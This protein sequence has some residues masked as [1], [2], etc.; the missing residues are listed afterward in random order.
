MPHKR[1]PVVCERISGLARVVRGYALTALEDVALW[2]E[3]DISHSS[4]ERIVFPDATGLLSFMLRELTWV[5][6]GLHVFPER[7]RANVEVAGGI[8][9]SQAVLLA[10]VDAG[11]TRDDAYGLVQ[12]AAA[13]AWDRGGSFRAALERTPAIAERLDAAALDALFDPARALANLGHVFEKLEKLPVE[14]E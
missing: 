4:A 6:E 2:H 12:A 10:L 14:S 3:R 1:N 11:M 8:V 13:E 7:M 9:S 5:L